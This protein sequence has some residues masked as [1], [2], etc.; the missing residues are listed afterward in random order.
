MEVK[1]TDENF[2][3]LIAENSVVVVDFGATWCGPCRAL[4][5]AIE[6]LA[7]T[8]QGKAVVG[9][10]DIEESPETTEKYAIRSVPTILFFKD[11]KMVPDLKTVGLTPEKKLA[12]KID[13]L[14]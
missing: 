2:E 10:I 14:L 7:A 13:T 6:N 1:F 8:Y 9:S 12:D 3:K 5:P 11:G 4:A